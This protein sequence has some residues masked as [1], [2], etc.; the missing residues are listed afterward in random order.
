[1]HILPS[2]PSLIP[3]YSS[4]L[5][6]FVFAANV[7][8]P[9][10]SRIPIKIPTRKKNK[11]KY[12]RSHQRCKPNLPSTQTCPCLRGRLCVYVCV[13][14]WRCGGEGLLLT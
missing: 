14:S 11:K 10:L 1:T 5:V 7:P 8:S 6:L 13:G 2:F 12:S 9:P 4:H 3:S